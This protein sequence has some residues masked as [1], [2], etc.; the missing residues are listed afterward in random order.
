MIFTDVKF[1][2]AGFR[3]LKKEGIIKDIALITSFVD[4]LNLDRKI[5]KE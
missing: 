5:F 2:A 1:S 4:E 3:F